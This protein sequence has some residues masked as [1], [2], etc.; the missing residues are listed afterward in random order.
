MDNITSRPIWTPWIFEGASLS[1]VK[2]GSSMPKN[3]AWALARN[4]LEHSNE[5]L[6]MTVRMDGELPV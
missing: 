5:A 1:P 3:A 6:A 2:L 4:A